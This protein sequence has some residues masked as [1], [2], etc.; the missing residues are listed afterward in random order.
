M[1]SEPIAVPLP[2]RIDGAPV[3]AHA[4]T[5]EGL[6]DHDAVVVTVTRGRYF[7]V[8]NVWHVYVGDDG[9]WHAETPREGEP[10]KF[11]N[12]KTALHTM[13]ERVMSCG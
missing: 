6:P 9:T 8:F 2:A 7:D 10:H 13:T 4:A 12:Y 5:A 3:V 11:S 1:I